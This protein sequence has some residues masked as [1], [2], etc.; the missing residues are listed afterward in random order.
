MR[1]I[2]SHTTIALLDLG[3]RSQSE[4]Q[5]SFSAAGIPLL[6]LGLRSASSRRGDRS[7]RRIHSAAGEYLNPAAEKLQQQ[8]TPFQQ[9]RKIRSAGA[10][11]EELIPAA[12]AAE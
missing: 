10:A 4:I 11:A 2:D 7:S 5:I 6:D 1:I 12:A 8:E 3:E 9:Q